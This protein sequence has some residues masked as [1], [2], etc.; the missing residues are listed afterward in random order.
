MRNNPGVIEDPRSPEEKSYDFQHDELAKGDEAPVVWVE[1]PQETWKK[2]IVR[3]QDGSSSCVAHAV[4]KMIGIHQKEYKD[5]SPKFI[6]LQRSNYPDGGMWLP[7]AL[8]LACKVGT[9]PEEMLPCENKGESWLNDKSKLTQECIEEAK[10]YRRGAY[11]QVKNDMDTIARIVDKGIP[12]LIGCRFDYDEWTTVP[13]VRPN[14]KLTCGHGIALIDRTL[15]NGKKAFII[16]DSWGPN[17]GVGGHRVLTEDFFKARV[18]YIGYTTDLMLE[19]SIT[20]FKYKWST[21]MKLGENSVDISSLQKALMSIGLF[22]TTA[23]TKGYYG[24]ITRKAVYEFQKKYVEK[25]NKGVQVGPLTLKAL[26]K[27][28]HE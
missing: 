3:N 13:F 12:L 24:P 8:D 19:E 14:S 4:A 5:L 16:E 20:K 26:N 17:H 11:F 9:C 28:F 10:K 27:I 18:F 25:D 23:S 2:Y 6:Y 15:Y 1:K 22:P 7:N 21:T